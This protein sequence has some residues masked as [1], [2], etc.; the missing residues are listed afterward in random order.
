MPSA[1]TSAL[2]CGAAPSRAT[3]QERL[4]VWVRSSSHG[5]SPAR[6]PKV[7]SSAREPPK[8]RSA[9]S[10]ARP[11]RSARRKQLRILLARSTAV[12]HA[13]T[14]AA[15]SPTIKAASAR[16]RPYG[17]RRRAGTPAEDESGGDRQ[18][19]EQGRQKG[20]PRGRASTVRWGPGRPRSPLRRTGPP[21]SRR[22][23]TRSA[24][25]AP[26]TD[27]V[28]KSRRKL[29]GI[30]S[31]Q[32]NC[33]AGAGRLRTKRS[34]MRTEYLAGKPLRDFAEFGRLPGPRHCYD[35]YVSM[36]R[37]APGHA[38]LRGVRR[39]CRWVAPLRSGERRDARCGS[40]SARLGVRG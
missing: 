18:N 9:S 28:E 2:R 27:P 14:K 16:E 37:S 38:G 21:A 30:P 31:R 19:E 5:G 35:S 12:L 33:M 34:R 39:L 17:R 6:T 11:P 29:P 1:K 10:G 40:A 24:A 25:P 13:R 20:L 22:S 3:V 15:T 23:R 32:G 7:T 36:S 4:R 26:N 8:R